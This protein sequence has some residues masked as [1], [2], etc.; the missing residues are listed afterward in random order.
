[1]I[2]KITSSEKF[3]LRVFWG[4]RCIASLK[5]WEMN[6]SSV[7]YFLYMERVATSERYGEPNEGEAM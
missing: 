4:R 2:P 3:M 5:D 1:L 7:G 6:S